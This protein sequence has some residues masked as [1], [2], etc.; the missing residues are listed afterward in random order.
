MG[1]MPNTSGLVEQGNID[2]NA[3]PI[4]K[5]PDGSISTVRSISVG[6]EKGEVLI[7]TVSDDGRI[8]SDADALE[9]YK[10]T[11]KHL[12]VFK[13]PEE[14]TRYAQTLHKDQD[15]MYANNSQQKIPNQTTTMG[16]SNTQPERYQ[17]SEMMQKQQPEMYPMLKEEKVTILDPAQQEADTYARLEKQ[18]MS[19]DIDQEIIGAV[20]DLGKMAKKNIIDPAVSAGKNAANMIFSGTNNVRYDRDAAASEFKGVK[21]Q[22]KPAK[23]VINVTAD[24]AMQDL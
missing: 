7:P 16:G 21:A 5:N 20:K 18:G 9:L 1:G 3:R 12:G 17:T 23:S 2:L 6:T 19:D 10:T 4:V 11:G 15:K 8:L 13:T 24:E 14:A 22:S